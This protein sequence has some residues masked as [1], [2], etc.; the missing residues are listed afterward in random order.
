MNGAEAKI[1]GQD[2]TVAYGDYVLL[3]DADF[4][5][6]KGDYIFHYGARAAAAKAVC[7]GSLQDL[8]RRQQAKL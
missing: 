8:C 4:T 2:I 1:I 3:K 6:N 5:V 7:C